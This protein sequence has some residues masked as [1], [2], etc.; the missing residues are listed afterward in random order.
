MKKINEINERRK[1][2]EDLACEKLKHI[3]SV[4]KHKYS[5][6]NTYEINKNEYVILIAEEDVF[7]R[8]A[9][10]LTR[11]IELD[12]DIETRIIRRAFCMYVAEIMNGV[13]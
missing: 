10:N 6:N 2:K 1:L 3:S 12:V 11:L 4:L 5:I 13:I 7:I 9:Y 8:H